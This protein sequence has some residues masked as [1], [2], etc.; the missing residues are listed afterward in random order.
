MMWKRLNERGEKMTANPADEQFFT[1]QICLC[2]FDNDTR[3]PKCL[4]RCG[5]T[6]CLLCGKSIYKHGIIRCPFCRMVCESSED[7]S[8][9]IPDNWAV[10]N[11]MENCKRNIPQKISSE[12]RGSLHHNSADF[13]PS[14]TSKTNVFPSDIK[15]KT[16][17]S[18]GWMESQQPPMSETKS[19]IACTIIVQPKCKT[20]NQRTILIKTDTPRPRDMPILTK[21][22]TA[23]ATDP[24]FKPIS[25]SVLEAEDNEFEVKY[26]PTKRGVYKFNL[27][28]FGKHVEGCPLEVEETSL[29]RSIFNRAFSKN[30]KKKPKESL[31]LLSANALSETR[32]RNSYLYQTRSMGMF[33][34][35]CAFGGMVEPPYY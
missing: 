27:N 3:R 26:T 31:L 1:C 17:T 12:H 32:A 21:G 13:C 35:V 22:L 19:S 8:T 11:M 9:V 4:P 33:D 24:N 6:L 29:R 7:I 34:E 25:V 15:S 2:S 10:R 18:T 20:T 30:T 23:E 14:Q 16:Y 5:H 28:L